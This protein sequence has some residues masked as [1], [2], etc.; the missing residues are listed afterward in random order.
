MTDSQ[1]L[2][3]SS[4]LFSKQFYQYFCQA[5]N[6]LI[7]IKVC[8]L[9]TIESRLMRVIII[10]VKN[11]ASIL[12]LF[13]TIKSLRVFVFLSPSS[14][15]FRSLVRVVFISLHRVLSAYLYIYTQNGHIKRN[16]NGRLLYSPFSFRLYLAFL[17]VKT[18][19]ILYHLCD[20][21]AGITE[22]RLRRNV[23]TYKLRFISRFFTF[24]IL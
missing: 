23:E 14:R 6:W 22:R 15:R 2:R 24:I 4:C 9:V 7:L 21:L 10:N 17:P 11:A 3:P 12:I 16:N 8:V 18:P 13:S 20:E 19:L 5:N 1:N